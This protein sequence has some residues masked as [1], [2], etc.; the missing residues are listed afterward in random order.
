MRLMMDFNGNN[1]GYAFVVYT[2]KK[3]AQTAVRMLNNYEVSLQDLAKSIDILRNIHYFK[4]FSTFV[5]GCSALLG[6]CNKRP[7]ISI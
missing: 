4:A 2:T 3:D 7:A 1:R 5:E 6:I